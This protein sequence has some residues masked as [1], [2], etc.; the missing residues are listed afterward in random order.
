MLMER[1]SGRFVRHHTH[2]RVRVAALDRCASMLRQVFGR[3]ATCR[4]E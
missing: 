3:E 1:P 4:T 2:R